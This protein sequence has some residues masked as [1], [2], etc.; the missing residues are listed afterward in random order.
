MGVSTIPSVLEAQAQRRI[1]NVRDSW[2][3]WKNLWILNSNLIIHKLS[4]SSES[5]NALRPDVL[6]IMLS[7]GLIRKCQM[8]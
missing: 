8:L 3:V 4:E 5:S 1:A 7:H 6:A 2:I